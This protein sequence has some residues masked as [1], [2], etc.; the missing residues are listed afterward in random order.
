LSLQIENNR[1]DSTKRVE[2]IAFVLV[3]FVGGMISGL[4]LLQFTNGNNNNASQTEKIEI[5]NANIWVMIDQNSSQAAVFLVNEDNT[6]SKIKEITVRGIE[7]SWSNVYYWTANIGSV[8]G[9]LELSANELSGSSVAIE[10][11]GKEQVFERA[12]GEISLDS[13]QTMILYINNPGDIT[14]QNAPVKVLLAIFT[15]RDMY[16]HE[17]SIERTLKFV[18]LPNVTITNVQFA[19][20]SGDAANTI[21]LTLKNTGTKA[22]TISAVKV[23]G[24]VATTNPTTLLLPAGQTDGSL[25]ITDAGWVVG[26]PYKFDLYDSSGQIAASYQATAP[27]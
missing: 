21:L 19:G 15:E 12:T 2:T 23:N 27:S 9:E 22:T 11:D 4:A 5:K 7:C 17:I 1:L 13:Y 20:T 10:V 14:P 3:I 18:E 8:T 24:Q 16:S 26:N 6:A 25:T